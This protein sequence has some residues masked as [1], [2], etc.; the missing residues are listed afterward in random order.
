MWNRGSATSTTS[1]SSNSNNRP[2]VSAFMYSVK[3]DSTAPLGP[4]VP[5]V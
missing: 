2:E 4:V 3:C 1:L 5:E